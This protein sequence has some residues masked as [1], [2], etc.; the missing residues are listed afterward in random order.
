VVIDGGRWW[1]GAYEVAAMVGCSVHSRKRG[2]RVLGQK[3][4][5]ELLELDFKRTFG[6]GGGRQWGEAVGWCVRGGV[7]GGVVRLAVQAWQQVWAKIS[8]PSCLGSV[9]GWHQAACG[10]LGCCLVAEPPA[11]V[12]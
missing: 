8:K 12:T 2:R 1:G 10:S 5:T 3:S 6:Y 7:S 4:E 9:S 11:V